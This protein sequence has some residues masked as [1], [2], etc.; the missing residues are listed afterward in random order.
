M[1]RR[2]GYILIFTNVFQFY[3]FPEQFLQIDERS[4]FYLP[5]E[6]VVEKQETHS[7]YLKSKNDE[8]YSL[9]MK[10]HSTPDEFLKNFFSSL[11]T[12]IVPQE[13]HL[14]QQ[15]EY[16][17]YP[18]LNYVGCLE[19]KFKHCFEI[20]NF[21]YEVKDIVLEI[22]LEQSKTPDE[23]RNLI[24]SLFFK[25]NNIVHSTQKTHLIYRIK[26]K[27]VQNDQTYVILSIIPKKDYYEQQYLIN[28]ISYVFNIVPKNIATI[29]FE[30]VL[31][32]KPFQFDVLLVLNNSYPM[33]QHQILLKEQLPYFFDRLRIL[34]PNFSMGL[35]TTNSCKLQAE[36]TKDILQIEKSIKLTDRRD[37]HSCVYYVEKFLSD[38]KCWNSKVPKHVS[39]IC[40]QNSP[41]QYELLSQKP[42]NYEKNIFKEKH[43]PFY[44]IV[45]ID[46]YAKFQICKE[47][48]KTQK[49]LEHSIDFKELVN[50][51]NGTLF[52]ICMEDYKT[53][54][55]DILFDSAFKFSKLKLSRIPV[56][57][58][59]EVWI[60]G[61]KIEPFLNL[62]NDLI[63]DTYYLFSELEN[64]ILLIGTPL[65]GKIKIN[66]LTLEH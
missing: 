59:L 61:K 12:F 25:N 2:M 7:I 40:I 36:F 32:P 58:S 57:Q 52:N 39:I 65:E 24:G 64:T 8:V 45:P 20:L 4:L 47:N 26:L 60:G 42:F 17:I 50:A 19:K 23:L 53:F 16:Q 43:I 37:L 38:S 6:F 29:K 18:K 54:L 27:I 14:L 51:T 22:I 56:P 44:A 1:Q 62:K 30:E 28:Q 34:N 48:I 41:D 15:K 55:D 33:K 5:Q 66:Y 63:N 31:E 46:S 11:N 10:L 9:F 13:L 49:S 21:K 35:L 3:I